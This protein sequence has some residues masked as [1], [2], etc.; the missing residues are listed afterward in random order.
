MVSDEE[1]NK[2]AGMWLL[3]EVYKRELSRLQ[4]DIDVKATAPSAWSAAMVRN[5]LEEEESEICGG[6]LVHN[7]CWFV[8]GGRVGGVSM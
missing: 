2:C 1:R 7:V 3:F 6:M 5:E 8:F 4:P